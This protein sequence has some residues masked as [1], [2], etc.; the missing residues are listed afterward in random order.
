MTAPLEPA[1]T[2]LH[3]QN[4][5]DSLFSTGFMDPH[6]SMIN[7]EII[8]RLKSHYVYNFLYQIRTNI[9]CTKMYYKHPRQS[10]IRRLFISQIFL[11]ETDIN[12]QL[13]ANHPRLSIKM[14]KFHTKVPPHVT[15][16]NTMCSSNILFVRTWITRLLQITRV[17][18]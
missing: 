14:T 7:T 18:P 13:I 2:I 12:N 16:K 8:M 4:T 1:S 5:K 9:L 11:F 10:N 15:G 3:G 6:T 17:I